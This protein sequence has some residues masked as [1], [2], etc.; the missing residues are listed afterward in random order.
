[1]YDDAVPLVVAVQKTMDFYRFSAWLTTA[2]ALA[3]N[4]TLFRSLRRRA[5]RLLAFLCGKFFTCPG[6][7]AAAL[8]FLF[9]KR[10]EVG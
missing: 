2:A 9:F 6:I 4:A 10:A 3:E 7:Q 1:M 5:E 8:G